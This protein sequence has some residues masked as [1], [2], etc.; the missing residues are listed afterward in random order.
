[1]GGLSAA[2]AAGS[3][4]AAGTAG[5]AGSAG[6]AGAAGTSALLASKAGASG[7][8]ATSMLGPMGMAFDVKNMFDSKKAAKKQ[9]RNSFLLQYANMQRKKNILEQQLATRHARMANMGISSSA[10]ADA[11]NNRLIDEA[12]DEI[13]ND[14]MAFLAEQD[15]KADGFN[16]KY[17]KN[18]LGT[19]RCRKSFKIK[20]KKMPRPKMTY[21]DRRRKAYEKELPLADQLDAVLKAFDM[22]LQDGGEL[23]YELIDVIEKWQEIKNRYPK[24]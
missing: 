15:A 17:R 4:G 12:F 7:L 22:V 9:A 16:L 13:E 14:N 11:A 19:C 24:E 2:A 10:S 5:T 20:E 23:P 1:M 18:L 21:R 3:A 8:S 6:L